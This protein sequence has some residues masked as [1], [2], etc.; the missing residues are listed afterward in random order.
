MSST[1]M[2]SEHG[3]PQ[4][5]DMNSLTAGNPGPILL[6]DFHLI[7][8]LAH[9]NRERIPERVVHAKGAGAHGY[10][11][12]THDIS[13]YCKAR[14]FNQVGKRTPLF[15]RFSTVGG[16]KGS[17]DT[18]R[19]PRGFAV[20]VYTEEG[21]WDMV[22]NN[23]PVFFIR[24]PIK[25]PDF[26][27]TQK[28]NAGSNLGDPDAVWDFLS[29]VP[30]SLHQVTILFSDR[31]TPYSYR[32]MNG[33]GSHTYKTVNAQGEAFWVK[34]HFKTETGVK[35]FNAA[36]AT[37]MAGE[38]ADWATRDLYNHIKN[39]GVAAW[40]F[41]IQAMPVEQAA[42]YRFDVFDVTKV[43][44]HKDFPLIP[45]GRMVLNRNPDNYF[46]E[47]E[48]SAFS[49][50]NVVPGIEI[51]YDKMLQARTFSYPDTHRHRLGPNFAQIPI[52]FPRNC[53]PNNYHRDGF[54]CVTANGGSGPNY[55]PNSVAGTPMPS[56]EFNESQRGGAVSGGI[57]RERTRHPN[58]DFVQPG[59]LYRKVM[60]Q[61][62]RDHLIANIVGHLKN[63][64]RDIQAK[65]VAI[66]AR[67]DPDYG[68]RVA[69][70]LG[71]PA[72]ASL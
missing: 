8:K 64:R 13:K 46:A 38:D 3:I 45:V 31:G 9:F 32:H 20:K 16:E 10:L 72:P 61:Q 51:S 23:T 65:M 48:Q 34:F 44:P 27:H 7:E 5:D 42:S 18:A 26:I 54:M 19:D 66:F 59:E 63:A 24:D 30:E 12:I 69:R 15:T 14:V 36:D 4:P 1:R 68:S 67:A 53:P 62:D 47:V 52:N 41:C 25:F 2:T 49:P 58:D 28:R 22:G 33:Y 60:T 70:G 21:N 11:E 43:W 39:G 17:A 56:N 35:N 57:M 50:S 71:L 40:S 37:R 55:F 29:L 6:Q